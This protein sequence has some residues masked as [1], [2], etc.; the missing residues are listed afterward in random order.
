MTEPPPSAAPLASPERRQLTALGCGLC[1]PALLA[2]RRDPE[3]LQR[4]LVAFRARCA[5]IVEDA[6]GTVA[7]R[8]GE[9]V[10]AY[11][12]YPETHEDAAERAVRA[13][14]RLVETAGEIEAGP[15]GALQ[16]RVGIA[17]GL[18]LVGD[19]LGAGAG[20]RAV[21]GEIPDLATRL[22]ARA[23]PGT[24][25]IGAATQRLVG[26]TFRYREHAPT[27]LE[28]PADPL[29]AWEV[30]GAGVASRFEAL[31]GPEVAELVGREEELFLLRR[32]WEQA[33]TGAGRVV[34]ITGEP[35]IG[36][37]RLVRAVQERVAGER[38]VLPRYF[39]APHHRDSAL[40]P[41]IAQLE[42][43]AG[44][45]RGDT[46]E[47]K[48]AKLRALLAKSDASDETVA[49][50]AAL[51]S[52]PV[53][54]PYRLPEASPQTLRE[55]TLAALLEL[56][57]GLVAR[58]PALVVFEDLHWADP[59]TLELL[60]RT[61]AR[62][63]SM[64]VLLLMTA[65]PEFRPP[66]PDQAHAGT[67]PLNRLSDNEAAA[68][69]QHAAGDA[70]L[71]GAVLRHIVGRAEG[72]PLFVE[73]LT[74]TVLESGALADGEDSAPP[75]VPTSL[76]DLLL[77][78]LDRLGP[79]RE[80]AQLGAVIGREFTHDLLSAVAGQPDA[81]LEPALAGIVRS[82]LLFRSGAPPDA[83]YSF[84]HALVH[85]PA[86]ESLPR[87]RRRELHARI[88]A[89]LEERLAGDAEQP[90]DLLVHHATLAE[91]HSLAVR[92][93]VAAGERCLKIFANEEALRLADRG[94]V[95]L[96]HVPLGE[97]RVRNL[98][99]LLSLKVFAAIGPGGRSIPELM[100]QLQA[101]ADAATEMGLHGDATSALITMAA[102][103]QRLNKAEQAG[104]TVLRAERA[105]RLADEATHCRQ[106]ANA[107]RCL[108]EVEREIPRALGLVRDAE[109][110]AETLGLRFA[111]LEWG[112]AHAARWEGDLDRAHA[113]MSEACDLARLHEER[114]RESGCL[115][116]LATIDLERQRF[117]SVLRHCDAV[118][119]IAAR[120]GQ[121]QAPVADA[122]RAL[123]RLASS[124]RDDTSSLDRGLAALR[125]FDDKTQ[126]A[127]ALNYSAAFHLA[128]GRSG[129]ARAAATEAMA[130]ARAVRRAT[131]IAV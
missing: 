92:A 122:L 109:A 53:G 69:A 48:L 31:R 45:G 131:E 32:R 126:L 60:A 23:E 61:V 120:M 1:G 102:I 39:C 118:E 57:A 25:L 66:W 80:V 18:A 74:K 85:Q 8:L 106:I 49:L 81:A 13:A 42:G 119:R 14:L 90:S 55:K 127:Y 4:L 76:H 113:L 26:D 68:L 130:T 65:R 87:G 98:I 3:D 95:Q 121:G 88:A 28:G 67:L 114:W 10:L 99:A 46:A 37:S 33:K 63:A 41:V 91:N 34:L 125:E 110:L 47:A 115:A 38:P 73:E 124:G 123:A 96:D 59:T 83:R 51:L 36:K 12:G 22:L 79:A 111:E 44:F 86:Y 78:R 64:R 24:V 62:V 35:G 27:A 70:C 71:P 89:V 29:A 94:L 93:C 84:K 117:E 21:V 72:T 58:G 40:Y 101:A 20:E 52:I 112:R 9:T 17:T 5:A 129:Q 30:T 15:P 16:V 56:F 97:E 105:S 11:F 43:V 108:L 75:P 77:A 116:W 6:G 107:G 19:L 128:R 82:E 104:Q 2:A 100:D 7:K 103:E 50:I 54:E